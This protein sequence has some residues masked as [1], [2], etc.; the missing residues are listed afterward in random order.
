MSGT[1]NRTP[2]PKCGMVNNLYIAIEMVAS[3]LATWSLAG[4]QMKVPAR[5]RPVL[6]CHNCDF[7]LP[8]EYDGDS[9]AVFPRPEPEANSG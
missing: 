1:I 6:K 8:G 9:H 2:C 7:N 4:N 5:E 3:P